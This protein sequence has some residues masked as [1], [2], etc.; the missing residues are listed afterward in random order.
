MSGRNNKP[1]ELGQT[2][3]EN[4]HLEYKNPFRGKSYPYEEFRY[5]RH[6]GALGAPLLENFG[7][8]K[9]ISSWTTLAQGL[10]SSLLP[11]EIEVLL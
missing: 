11:E 7:V 3:T 6:T 2:R 10:Y 8:F 4:G 5:L 9:P 1:R